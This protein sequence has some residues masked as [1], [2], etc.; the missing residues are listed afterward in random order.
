MAKAN[1]NSIRTFPIGQTANTGLK[2]SAIQDEHDLPSHSASAGLVSRRSVMN[3]LVKSSVVAAACQA[4]VS[5]SAASATACDPTEVQLLDLERKASLADS[6]SIEAGRSFS[7]S[8][9]AMFA[10]R[11]RN[12]KPELRECTVGEVNYEGPP[13]V[14]G[15]ETY[16]QYTTL[17]D[18]ANADMKAALAEHCEAA[19]RWN[20]RQGV[21][22]ANC[23]FDER[24]NEF[25]RLIVEAD[26]LREEAASIRAN[27]IGGLRIKARMA[28]GPDGLDLC[29]EDHAALAESI[30]ADLEVLNIAA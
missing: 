4:F 22:R 15:T 9:K 6:A 24:N 10:W 19:R 7:K 23:H 12:P 21:A 5:A 30:L 27:T 25:E 13:I 29:R 11:R 2:I 14:Y 28:H 3:M 1:C 18:E 16:R 20:E 8:E 17:V 26:A